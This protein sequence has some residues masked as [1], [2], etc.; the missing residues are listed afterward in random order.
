[1][2]AAA[3]G[4][5]PPVATPVAPP[6]SY[7]AS[8]TAS[9]SVA[10]SVEDDDDLYGR[11]KS[12]QRHMEF[13]EIQEEYVKDEQKNLK[14]ELL[15]AQEEVKRIQSV[16]LVI[17]QFMEMVDGNNGIVGSTTGSNYYVRILSTI[18]RELLKPSASVALHR[19]SNALVD[20]LPPEADSSISLLGSSEK[21]NVTY[22]VSLSLN[23]PDPHEALG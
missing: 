4:P 1:M 17:G 16:P 9:A 23:L 18:N 3:T 2:S 22:N 7:P 6:P 12:L 5:A 19:H 8:S 21:P 20:V 11:L 10:A 15:R 14:R 13:V